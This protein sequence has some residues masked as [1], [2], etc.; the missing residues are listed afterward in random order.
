MSEFRIF[1]CRRFCHPSQKPSERGDFCVKTKGGADLGNQIRENLCE[2]WDFGRKSRGVWRKTPKS[3]IENSFT[4]GGKRKCVWIQMYLRFGKCA[5]GPFER[6]WRMK[7]FED[8]CFWNEIN[9]GWSKS[10]F[11]FC[12]C[13]DLTALY[14]VIDYF[15]W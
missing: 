1:S 4:F 3:F 2:K 10:A 15:G 11:L 13:L 14:C 8:F 9:Y 12:V 5:S 7:T 6:G